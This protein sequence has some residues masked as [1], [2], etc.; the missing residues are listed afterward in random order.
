MCKSVT[1]CGIF[2]VV[3][4]L[5]V[6]QIMGRIDISMFFCRTAHHLESIVARIWESFWG[7]GGTFC[8]LLGASSLDRF[9]AQVLGRRGGFPFGGPSPPQDGEGEQTSAPDS[10]EEA[11]FGRH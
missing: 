5:E 4:L 2:E 1:K 6:S 7:Y 9:L 11:S 10:Q 8:V 3:D